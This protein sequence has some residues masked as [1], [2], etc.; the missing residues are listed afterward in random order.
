MDIRVVSVDWHMHQDPGSKYVDD[1]TLTELLQGRNESSNMQHFFQLLLNWSTINDT[2]VN[3]T[4]T[5]EM[6]M[7]PVTLSSNLPLIQWTEGQIERV[8]SF[9]LLG[10]HLDA[11][12]S[13]H[14][15]VEAVT[16]KVFGSDQS[17]AR[18]R[19]SCL[20]ITRLINPKRTRLKQ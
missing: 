16:S 8:N 14:S 11:D 5:K 15:H 4:K 2:A 1:T 10:L 19:S 17:C 3:F 6:V 9:K 18:I 7:G 13:W 20:G 12:F